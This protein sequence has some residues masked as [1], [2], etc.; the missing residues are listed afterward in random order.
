MKKLILLAGALLV[1]LSVHAQGIAS[2]VYQAATTTLVTNGW[3][4]SG[5]HGTFGG[6]ASGTNYYF[7][8]YI[9]PAG[10]TAFSS[11]SPAIGTNGLPVIASMR[12]TDTG[13]R[14]FG[15][16][17]YLATN[18]GTYAIGVRGWYSEG[19]PTGQRQGQGDSIVVNAPSGDPANS[20]PAKPTFGS[21]LL[22]GFTIVPEPSSIAL[23]LLGL[24]TVVLIRRRK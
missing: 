10:S 2:Y 4:A 20:V 21:G 7:Q 3:D 15:G 13:G 14:F 16:T 9:G 24:G 5:A 17:I 22:Q 6:N 19:G 23:G 18:P 12:S 1:T 11:L 8:L